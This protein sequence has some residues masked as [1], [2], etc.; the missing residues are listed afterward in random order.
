MVKSP[1]TLVVAPLL[2]AAFNDCRGPM[3]T[4]IVAPRREFRC[5]SF[6]ATP[7]IVVLPPV[8][9]V[10][11]T[12]AHILGRPADEL[13]AGLPYPRPAGNDI[14]CLRYVRRVEFDQEQPARAEWQV[15]VQRERQQHG[16]R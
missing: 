16:E 11:S 15:L 8:Y 5:R 13:T 14:P 2:T 1:P 7:S 3:G 9:H 6:F 12:A 10:A 4:D